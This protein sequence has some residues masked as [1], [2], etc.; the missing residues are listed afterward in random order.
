MDV[1]LD[2]LEPPPLGFVEC[3]ILPALV[4]VARHSVVGVTVQDTAE[5]SFPPSMDAW[6]DALDPPVG[7]VDHTT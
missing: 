4:S 7:F 6:D 1:V 2:Q 3:Q 5:S